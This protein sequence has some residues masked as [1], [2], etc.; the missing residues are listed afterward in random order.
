[1]GSLN[2]NGARDLEEFKKQ[3]DLLHNHLVKENKWIVLD[4][5]DPNCLKLV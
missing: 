3:V 1:M 4:S 5:K 2:I